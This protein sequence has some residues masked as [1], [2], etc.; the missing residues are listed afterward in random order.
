MQYDAISVANWIVH[1]VVCVATDLRLSYLQVLVCICLRYQLPKRRHM[2]AHAAGDVFLSAWPPPERKLPLRPKG[3]GHERLG[4]LII[5]T[6]LHNS[7]TG[8]IHDGGLKRACSRKKNHSYTLRGITR[9]LGVRE[10]AQGA[11]LLG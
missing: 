10:K 8:L 7:I 5:Y 1:A 2:Y 3:G 4:C 9:A 11:A 6:F